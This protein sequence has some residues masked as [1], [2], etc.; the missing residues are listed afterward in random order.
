MEAGALPD[1]T[2][3]ATH[4]ILAGSAAIKLGHPAIK[5][6]IVTDSVPIS[7]EKRTQLPALHIVSLAPLLA[8]AIWHLHRKESLSTLF[9]AHDD[10][11]VSMP[12]P[13]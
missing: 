2:V 12:W 7:Q 11:E 6:I 5:R 9:M 10:D 3:A 8:A 4:A 1:I 13:L